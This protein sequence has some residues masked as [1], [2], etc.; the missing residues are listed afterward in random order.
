VFGIQKVIGFFWKNNRRD[1]QQRGYSLTTPL[2]T[3]VAGAIFVARP[4]FGESRNLF[5]VNTRNGIWKFK[6]AKPKVCGQQIEI[7]M[8]QPLE[9][10][11]C[12]CG[13]EINNAIS[14]AAP[15]IDKAVLDL[16]QFAFDTQRPTWPL[17][18]LS[19]FFPVAEYVDSEGVD[20]V[21]ASK[22]IG[23]C[24]AKTRRTE[25]FAL[26]CSLGNAQNV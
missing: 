3:Y 16:T 15:S 10:H 24:R 19:S 11:N 2:A 1:Y 26:Q 12:R 9:Y 17:E 18:P 20:P 7:R 5:H 4:V 25:V 14:R 6:A 22:T 21:N 13:A 8:G 23:S